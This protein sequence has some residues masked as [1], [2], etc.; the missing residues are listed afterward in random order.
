MPGTANFRAGPLLAFSCAQLPGR[1]NRLLTVGAAL[2]GMSDIGIGFARYMY[3]AWRRGRR[4][5]WLPALPY[6]DLLPQPLEAVRRL[7]CIEPPEVAHPGGIM[8]GW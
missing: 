8:R 4:A 1:A 5:A 3:R 6:E 2:H 7:A